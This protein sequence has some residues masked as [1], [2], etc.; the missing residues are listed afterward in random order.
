MQP[1]G[2]EH[3]NIP[4]ICTL[5]NFLLDIVSIETYVETSSEHLPRFFKTMVET[6]RGAIGGLSGADLSVC[7]ATTKKGE[8]FLQCGGFKLIPIFPIRLLATPKE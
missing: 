5:I 6:V 8:I 7:L 3:T 4:E 1:V 2:S